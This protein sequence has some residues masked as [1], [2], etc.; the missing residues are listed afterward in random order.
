M[1]CF[2]SMFAC[3]IPPFCRAEKQEREFE[4]VALTDKIYFFIPEDKQR[5]F[6]D[7]GPENTYLNIREYLYLSKYETPWMLD[8]PGKGFEMKEFH[9][10]Q[11]LL[12]GWV[13]TGFR[14]PGKQI[15]QKCPKYLVEG[16]S[17]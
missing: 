10:N 7:Y 14:W 5:D 4:N 6:V 9:F 15:E 12:R 8:N 2:R 13:P 17:Y 3:C 16:K 11:A 1:S